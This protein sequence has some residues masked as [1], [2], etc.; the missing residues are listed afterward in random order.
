MKN[1]A[2]QVSMQPIVSRSLK[3]G[4]PVFCSLFSQL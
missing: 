4:L 1:E 2:Y 3:Q